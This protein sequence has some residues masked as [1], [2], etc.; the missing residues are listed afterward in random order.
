MD[1]RTQ[2]ISGLVAQA[3]KS[4]GSFGGKAMIVGMVGNQGYEALQMILGSFAAAA[5]LDEIDA[6]DILDL[7]NEMKGGTVTGA[8]YRVL[9][10]RLLMQGVALDY[11][12]KG[13]N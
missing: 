4:L 6:L 1:E 5:T 2:M 9:G 7:A 3:N 13:G 12:E 10:A 8:D 11:P